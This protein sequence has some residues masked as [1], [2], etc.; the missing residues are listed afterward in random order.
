[1]SKTIRRKKVRNITVLR[2]WCYTL[3]SKHKDTIAYKGCLNS[4]CSVDCPYRDDEYTI[5]KFHRDTRPNYGWKGAAPKSFRKTVER[6]YRAKTK[7]EVRRL[8]K[9]ED[10]HNYTFNKHVKDAGW[11][12]W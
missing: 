1:M 2:E 10:Y 6:E 12:Y 8:Y 3:N 9:T 11:R 4:C 5:S 7:A